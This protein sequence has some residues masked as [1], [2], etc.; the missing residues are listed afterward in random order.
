MYPDTIGDIPAIEAEDWFNGQDVEPVLIS[1]KDYHQPTRLPT[2]S[3]MKVAKKPNILD[4][5]SANKTAKTSPNNTLTTP[6][7]KP[8]FIQ[9]QQSIPVSIINICFY[10]ICSFNNLIFIL[11]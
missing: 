3:E 11:G 10:L 9:P 6:V 7:P 8:Q 1:L 5:P 2:A 4:K